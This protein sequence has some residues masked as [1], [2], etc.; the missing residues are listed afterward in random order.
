M[1]AS[2]RTQEISGE[3]SLAYR[4][5]QPLDEQIQY[6]PQPGKDA[7]GFRFVVASQG[8]ENKTEE[9]PVEP[10]ALRISH[11]D[12]MASHWPP[13][14]R[15]QPQMTQ[16]PRFD[17]LAYGVFAPVGG[18]I[19]KELTHFPAEALLVSATFLSV[20]RCASLATS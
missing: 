8:F 16:T 14:N 2:N 3:F 7:S 13:A 15:N 20:A 17:S 12:L 9:P 4:W 5:L 11:S 10:E 1:A 18:K 19:S 6:Y